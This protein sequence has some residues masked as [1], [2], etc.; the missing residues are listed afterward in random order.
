MGRLFQQK[1]LRHRRA[2][3]VN[4]CAHWGLQWGIMRQYKS[5]VAR[6]GATRVMK[7]RTRIPFPNILT[8]PVGVR[9]R[10]KDGNRNADSVNTCGWGTDRADPNACAQIVLACKETEGDDGERERERERER[11]P[12]ALGRGSGADGM[13]AQNHYKMIAN[14]CTFRFGT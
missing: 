7:A 10:Q 4:A 12:Q 14:F 13:G 5:S 1:R 8:S 11:L 2:F 6:C 9:G 3:H